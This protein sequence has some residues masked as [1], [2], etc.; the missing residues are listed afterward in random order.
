MGWGACGWLAGWLAGCVSVWVVGWVRAASA[1][2]ATAA[3]ATAAFAVV[4]LELASHNT[5]SVDVRTPVH[6][7]PNFRVRSMEWWYNVSFPNLLRF[8]MQGQGSREHTEGST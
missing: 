3:A 8:S 7:Q 5:W 1:A 2:A 6:D 4:C